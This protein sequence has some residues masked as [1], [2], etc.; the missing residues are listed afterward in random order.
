MFLLR[1]WTKYCLKGVDKPDV[2]F[3]IHH[4]LPKSI[5]GYYQVGISLSNKSNDTKRIIKKYII[6]YHRRKAAGQAAIPMM[7]TA[8][9]TTVTKTVRVLAS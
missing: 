7:H 8:S 9:C 2:R 1:S 6:F 4:A 5:E 3:V